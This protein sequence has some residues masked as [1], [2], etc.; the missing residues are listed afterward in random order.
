MTAMSGN[1]EYPVQQYIM[2]YL[3]KTRTVEPEKHPFLG[4]GHQA[5]KGTTFA[6]TQHILKNKNRWPLLGK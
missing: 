1:T 4:N 6:A 3:L 5:E 2:P